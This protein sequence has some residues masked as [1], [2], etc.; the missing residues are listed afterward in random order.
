MIAYYTL[1]SSIYGTLTKIVIISGYKTTFKSTME[2]I[3]HN[4]YSYNTVELS[5]K[6][7]RKI[8]LESSKTLG[9]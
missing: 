8:Y 9:D 4:L 5:K 7:I 2:N 1:F 3:L 6:E